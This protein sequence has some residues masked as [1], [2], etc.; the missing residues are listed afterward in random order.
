MSKWTESARDQ[1]CQVRL[2]GCEYH[3]A[4]LAH[5]RRKWNA[6][7]GMKPAD[8][9]GAFACDSC[10]A[11]LDRRAGNLTQAEIDAAFLDGHLR[12]LRIWEEMGYL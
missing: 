4:I 1:Q 11:Q 6:G 12:T 10:H 3:T 5:I 8:Y 9:M 2:P 7:V